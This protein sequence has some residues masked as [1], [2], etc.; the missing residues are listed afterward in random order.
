MCK[1]LS[2][3]L[4]GAV[5]VAGLGPAVAKDVLDVLYPYPSLFKGMHEDLSKRFTETKPDIEVR[6]RAPAEDYE[7]ATQQVL[8]GA[9]ADKLPDI[10]YHGLNR[11]RIFVE[12][13]LAVSLAPFIAEKNSGPTWATPMATSASARSGTQSMGCR[14]RSPPQFSMSMAIW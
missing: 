13:N 2:V 10:A 1:A 3:V 14:S 6:F 5:L 4:F 12:R 11:I 9:V 7:D 8:R